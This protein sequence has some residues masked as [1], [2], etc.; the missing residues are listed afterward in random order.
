MKEGD[1]RADHASREDTSEQ[2]IETTME[3]AEGTSEG[4]AISEVDT[5]RKE[6]TRVAM[7]TTTSRAEDAD[8]SRMRRSQY[9][10]RKYLRR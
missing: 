8:R 9:R 3:E 1:I 5:T 6:G 4:A 7:V 2:E 10:G